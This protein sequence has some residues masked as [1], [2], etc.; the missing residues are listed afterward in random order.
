MSD[1]QVLNP[2]N[3]LPTLSVG[4]FSLGSLILKGGMSEEEE[5]KE[6]HEKSSEPNEI[7]AR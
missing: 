2:Y 6:H 4:Y 1:N 7:T 5:S 3:M